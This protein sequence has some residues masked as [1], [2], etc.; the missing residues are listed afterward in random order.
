MLLLAVAVAA[1]VVAL[2]YGRRALLA[3]YVWEVRRQEVPQAPGEAI[4]TYPLA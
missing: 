1:L 3:W 2:A 4:L